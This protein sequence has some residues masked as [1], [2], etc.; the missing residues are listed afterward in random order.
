MSK[1]ELLHRVNGQ[2]LTLLLTGDLTAAEKRRNWI[3]TVTHLLNGL[4]AVAKRIAEG[5]A[6]DE[7]LGEMRVL[8]A[9]A[10]EVIREMEEEGIPCQSTPSTLPA[11]SMTS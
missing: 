11:R 8:S 3:P 1:F 6:D 5:V 2:L 4:V 10:D 7:T 9:R